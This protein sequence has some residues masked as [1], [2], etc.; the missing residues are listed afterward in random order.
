MKKY[1]GWIIILIALVITYY[2]LDWIQQ[3]PK[4]FQQKV[5]EHHKEL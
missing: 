3:N 4:E 5:Q 2:R 1:L